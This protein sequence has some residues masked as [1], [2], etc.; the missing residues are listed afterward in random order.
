MM[1]MLSDMDFLV[2]GKT[3]I[4]IAR[5]ATETATIS[6]GW[7]SF[8]V[9][10]DWMKTDPI[11]INVGH[12]EELLFECG[13]SLGIGFFRTNLKLHLQLIGRSGNGR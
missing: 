4:K 12:N 6:P 9:Y 11:E 2:D 13:T 7:H 1:S 8:H 10:I 3:I 5:N